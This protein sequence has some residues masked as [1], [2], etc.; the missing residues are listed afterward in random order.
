MAYYV[1]SGPSA[2]DGT[3][4]V[5]LATKAATPKAANSKTG[6]MW[7]FYILPDGVKPT[8]AIATG[9]DRAVC[10][11]CVHRK[12]NSGTCYTYGTGIV[13]ANGMTRVHDA[14]NSREFSPTMVAGS[15]VRLGSYG[16]PAA[17]PYDVWAPIVAA[18]NGWTGYTHQ[19]RT[20]DQR[21]KSLCMA[22][23]DGTDDMAQATAAGW[24]TYT[25]VPV[26]TGRIPGAVP[27]PSPRVKCED[28]LK[29]SG[30]GAGRRGNVSIQAHGV[31][32]GKFRATVGQSL[33]LSVT[34]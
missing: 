6:D 15:T 16:D 7:Q 3:P 23:C 21:F 1:W 9:Q 34:R 33:P 19:W 8:T 14:G 20:C 25:V 12:V 13:A 4:I 27:C 5:V 2:I 30:T 32:A 26:G 22:S 28:C 11:D 31:L 29:C 17:V 24:R 10:G 18:S